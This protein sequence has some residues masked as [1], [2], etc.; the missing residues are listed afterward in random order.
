MYKR[1]VHLFAE[2]K[3]KMLSLC[4]IIRWQLCRVKA[5]W[6]IKCFHKSHILRKA[7]NALGEGDLYE[8]SENKS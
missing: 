4:G 6:V 2:A 7:V 1:T 3:R 5:S 8:W